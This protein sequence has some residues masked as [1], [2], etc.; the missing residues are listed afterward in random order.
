VNQSPST[1]PYPI[2]SLY[3]LIVDLSLSMLRLAPSF[4]PCVT[5]ASRRPIL[6]IV[7]HAADYA[8]D[9]APDLHPVPVSE[10]SIARRNMSYLLYPICVSS[11]CTISTEL[12]RGMSVHRCAPVKLQP[13]ISSTNLAS[14]VIGVH[15]L[16]WF[17]LA[18]ARCS[19]SSVWFSGDV[20]H[21]TLGPGFAHYF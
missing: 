1:V 2:I 14:G 18:S 7:T 6:I 9:N 16:A 10:A 8:R 11:L 19:S 3:P 17:K 12:L 4:L 15:L 21:R 20:R 5:L 13:A